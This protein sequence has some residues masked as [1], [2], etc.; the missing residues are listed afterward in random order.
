MELRIS[1][2]H[3]ATWHCRSK[4]AVKLPVSRALR[5]HAF[6]TR[7]LR[8]YALVKRA[9]RV[10]AAALQAKGD[11]FY[12]EDLK[13]KGALGEGESHCC[14][15]CEC[16]RTQSKEV[17]DIQFQRPGSYGQVFEVR[18]LAAVHQTGLSIF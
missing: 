9:L 12:A 16:Q 14:S 2:R 10:S 7:R 3:S 4:L 15:T 8:S 1:C 11:R 6:A 13:V 17:T 5:A 18:T